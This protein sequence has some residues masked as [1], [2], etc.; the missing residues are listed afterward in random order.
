MSKNDYRVVLTQKM[1][2]GAF[3]ELMKKKSIQSITIR[4]LCDAAGVNR[5]TFYSHYDDIYD[6]LRKI[7]NE[8]FN[9]LFEVAQNLANTSSNM[10]SF[11]DELCKYFKN[12]ADV[13]AML[14]S[15]H[16]D[17]VFLRKMV[18][19]GQQLFFGL[20]ADKYPKERQEYLLA[21]YKFVSGGCV[22][23]CRVWAENDFAESA[24]TM[25]STLQTIIE[26]GLNV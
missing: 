25:S 26:K 2:K 24:E 3:L 18:D 16:S 19:Y 6:L 14:F 20:Y 12:N 10:G 9:G 23:L 15:K 8:M 11:Y 4:E 7:E 21:Y 17:G 13:C 5:G 22:E 1:F